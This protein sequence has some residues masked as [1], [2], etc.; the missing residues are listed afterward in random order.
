MAWP[1]AWLYSGCRSTP[2]EPSGGEPGIAGEPLAGEAEALPARVIAI[3]A[4]RF[5]AYALTAGG[6]VWA[7]GANEKRQLGDGV[8]HRRYS[9][10]QVTAVAGVRSVATCD[11]YTC[12]AGSDGSVWE[13]GRHASSDPA[14]WEPGSTP[15]KLSGLSEVWAVAVGARAAVA[16]RSDGTVWAWG[17]NHLGQLG[18]GGVEVSLAPLR[19]AGPSDVKA[20][21]AGISCAYAM[22]SDGSVW[23]WGPNQ[24]GQLGDGTTTAAD[25]P[26]R[27]GP[28]VFG[29]P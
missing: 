16:L 17:C 7:W 18:N 26:V 29:S 6:N 3:A 19:V 8:P 10:V 15:R 13:W 20:V 21:A 27:V 23:A 25:V 4:G 2:G 24:F 12:A 22:K 11:G 14:S 1:L 5:S 9:P 28:G